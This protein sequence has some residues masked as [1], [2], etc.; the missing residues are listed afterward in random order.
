MPSSAVAPKRPW[1]GGQFRMSALFA[2]ILK[3]STKDGIR[4]VAW[5][6]PHL[7][8]GLLWLLIGRG[9]QGAVVFFGQCLPVQVKGSGL[10]G[11][12]GA[13]TAAML[14]YHDTS[15]GFYALGNPHSVLN[16]KDQ[17]T[18]FGGGLVSHAVVW[19][20]YRRRRIIGRHLGS[21]A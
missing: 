14:V 9:K 12:A 1:H 5:I 7:A 19:R 16:R 18:W 13:F 21:E 6:A 8:I 11:L 17:F 10:A 4:S 20:F 3:C 15:Q 2:E